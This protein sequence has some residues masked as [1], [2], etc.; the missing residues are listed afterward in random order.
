MIVCSFLNGFYYEAHLYDLDEIGAR[1]IRHM[2]KADRLSLHVNFVI[3]MASAYVVYRILS[4]LTN[5]KGYG[6]DLPLVAQVGGQQVDAEDSVRYIAGDRSL[7]AGERG[8]STLDWPR[9]AL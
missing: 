8:G 4:F 9:A 6:C 1:E 7:G 2:L 3:W 5:A